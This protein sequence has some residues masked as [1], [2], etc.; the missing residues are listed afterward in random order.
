MGVRLAASAVEHH[1][2]RLSGAGENCCWRPG[3]SGLRKAGAF[4]S[5]KTSASWVWCTDGTH[6]QTCVGTTILEPL[7][8]VC[9]CNSL[10]VQC[11][12][13]LELW[14]HQADGS[15]TPES[16]AVQSDKFA[17]VR[18]GKQWHAVVQMQQI[19]CA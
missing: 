11:P 17:S 6:H 7:S 13:A 16:V 12:E 10:A 8:P 3:H 1:T 15:L 4:R 18:N 9:A 5:Q 2:C 19:Q 14:D